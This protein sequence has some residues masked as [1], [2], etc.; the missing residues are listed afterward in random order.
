M[1]IKSPMKYVQ[2]FT[3]GLSRLLQ[4]SSGEYGPTLAISHFLPVYIPSLHDSDFGSGFSTLFDSNYDI[5]VSGVKGEPIWL[6]DQT[7][8][9]EYRAVD[10]N[11]ITALVKSA[12]VP[13]SAAVSSSGTYQIYENVIVSGTNQ[14]S[15]SKVSG[16]I[17]G[18]NDWLFNVATDRYDIGNPSRN[19]LFP[20]KDYTAPVG[21]DNTISGRYV[22]GFKDIATKLGLDKTNSS[23]LT[24]I[25]NIVN[26]KF[27]FNAVILYA[28]KLESTVQGDDRI[29]YTFGDEAYPVAI[30]GIEGQ[31]VVLNLDKMNQTGSEWDSVWNI[32]IDFV[33]YDVVASGVQNVT[34]RIVSEYTYWNKNAP[35]MIHTNNRVHMGM[36]VEPYGNFD[37]NKSSAA[38]MHISN[39]VVDPEDITRVPM[40]R[41]HIR[42]DSDKTFSTIEHK[43]LSSGNGVIE[44]KYS[45]I[46]QYDAGNDVSL[47]NTSPLLQ[48]MGASAFGTGDVAVGPGVKHVNTKDVISFGKNIVASGSS[49]ESGL[50]VGENVSVGSSGRI[51]NVLSIGDNAKTVGSNIIKVGN[52][53]GNN[54]ITVEEANLILVGDGNS[55]YRKMDT[56]VVVGSTNDFSATYGSANHTDADNLLVIGDGNMFSTSDG[57]F[58]TSFHNVRVIGDVNRLHGLN[59]DVELVDIIGDTCR[60]VS[61]SGISSVEIR[62]SDNVLDSTSDGA[63][64]QNV[65]IKGKDN[66]TTAYDSVEINGN[67]NNVGGKRIRVFGG[68]NIIGKDSEY[69]Y[70][71]G[72]G[73]STFGV[74]KYVRLMGGNQIIANSNVAETVGENINVYGGSSFSVVGKVVKVNTVNRSVVVGDNITEANMENS[75]R[76]GS[77]V[78]SNFSTSV[79]TTSKTANTVMVGKDI[80]AYNNSSSS[81]SNSAEQSLAVGLNIKI[82]N[83]TNVA[84]IGSNISVYGDNSFGIGNNIGAGTFGDKNCSVSVLGNDVS[85]GVTSVDETN[86][87]TVSKVG[88]TVSVVIGDNINQS[89]E[90]TYFKV[91]TEQSGKSTFVSMPSFVLGNN[92]YGNTTFGWT[93]DRSFVRIGKFAHAFEMSDYSVVDGM[94]EWQCPYGGLNSLTNAADFRIKL[95]HL[96]ESDVFGSSSGSTGETGNYVYF[97]RKKGNSN[98]NDVLFVDEYGYVRQ[99]SSYL[100]GGSDVGMMSLSKSVVSVVLGGKT[101]SSGYINVSQDEYN[102]VR[103]IVNVWI[104]YLSNP[105]WVENG[106]VHVP[107]MDGFEIVDGYG[108]TVADI[109]NLLSGLTN[110]AAR[111]IF[112]RVHEMFKLC[113]PDGVDSSSH[114]KTKH[115]L[116]DSI[117]EDVD[118]RPYLIDS[119]E[120]FKTPRQYAMA[121][122]YHLNKSMYSTNTNHIHAPCTLKPMPPWY[123]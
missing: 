14:Y 81:S 66:T 17:S 79:N 24:T 27:T 122:L 90:N 78:S 64:I 19:K 120:S 87:P 111:T 47:D 114:L 10:V 43:D 28:F 116:P 110:L 80:V 16:G 103:P 113:F 105:T 49:I 112:L 60:V 101:D 58:A 69:V 57:V 44:I 22:V 20:M 84:A 30:A 70:V 106:H 74:T 72:Y 104:E 108:Y 13:V 94:D 109:G 86:L 5:A 45:A 65:T 99:K 12:D 15:L 9:Y 123:T 119:A 100:D 8:R 121:I 117:A 39:K 63:K 118:F 56:A 21:S 1:G 40:D 2:P 53:K 31:P 6:P 46:D 25:T 102:A 41:R 18:V 97:N 59:S 52:G 71:D 7:V 76:V 34:H 115:V 4:N 32:D 61:P 67:G 77:N 73:I 50:I 82:H 91:I 54:A 75:V 107:Y 26:S 95:P 33:P 88:A 42:M 48:A 68:G 62:G 98:L 93:N 92:R 89:T 83:S 96:R 85:F 3:E 51:E 35:D 55:S 38:W 37:M 11:K 23:D 29:T 36:T